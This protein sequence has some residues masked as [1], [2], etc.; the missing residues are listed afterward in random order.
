[1]SK[2]WEEAWSNERDA[3]RLATGEPFALISITNHDRDA[4]HA[5]PGRDA[6]LGAQ[7][8]AQQAAV[9]ARA[10]LAAAA[11]ELTRALLAVEWSGRERYES[12]PACPVCEA[13]EGGRHAD[14]C[15]LDAALRKAGVRGG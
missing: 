14:D 8:E 2:P 6:S 3:L 7:I 11:P 15:A 12:W 13:G 10:R 4:Y 1:M 5:V 9:R